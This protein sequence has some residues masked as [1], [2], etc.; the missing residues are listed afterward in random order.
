MKDDAEVSLFYLESLSLVDYLIKEFGRESFLIFCQR[1]K[2]LKD[3]RKA[4]S[5]TYPFA[6]TQSLGEAWEKYL[7]QQ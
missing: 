4:L 6:D 1:L 7:L 3:F 2:E 5:T